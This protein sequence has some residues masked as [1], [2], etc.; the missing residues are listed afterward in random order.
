MN[1]KHIAALLLGGILF[2]NGCEDAAKT[3]SDMAI[4]AGDEAFNAVKGDAMKYV[5]DQAKGVSDA[6]DTAKAAFAKQDYA[7]AL[8]SAKDIAAKAEGPGP[9]SHESQGRIDRRLG[10]RHRCDAQ[11]G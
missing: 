6:I 3:G 9:G 4:K 5:P 2:L 8:S 7:G 11:D 10:R 1:L